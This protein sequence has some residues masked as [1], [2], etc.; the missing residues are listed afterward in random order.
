VVYNEAYGLW[1]CI[2]VFL[3]TTKMKDNVIIHGT[4]VE[5]WTCSNFLRCC[6]HKNFSSYFT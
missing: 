3:L 6:W 5:S 2:E 1:G 4:A